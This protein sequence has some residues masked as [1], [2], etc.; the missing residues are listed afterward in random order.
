MHFFEFSYND[1]KLVNGSA[2]IDNEKFDN[3]FNSKQQA[4]HV[5]TTVNSKTGQI[6]GKTD[7]RNQ[8]SITK[9]VENTYKPSNTPTSGSKNTQPSQPYATNLGSMGTTNPSTP[10]GTKNEQAALNDKIMSAIKGTELYDWFV[11]QTQNGEATGFFDLAGFEKDKNGVYHAKQ[12]AILQLCAGYNDLYDKAFDLACSMDFKKF[13]FSDGKEDFVIWLWK[14]DYLNLGGGA[15]VG[16]YNGGGP[17]WQYGTEYAMP[18]TLHLL[19]NK[20]GDTI[21][22]WMPKNDNWWCTGFNP[23]YQDV[24]ATEISAYGSIDFSK[25][26][27]HLEMFDAFS[28][29]YENNPMWTFDDANN[30]AYFKWLGDEK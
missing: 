1:F 25:D 17:Q 6:E 14:G 8:S 9:Q 2:I 5:N 26:S 18:M 10:Q 27:Q 23:K 29:K 21:F 30:I 24:K 11:K 15:E 7:Y 13:T 20:T 28:K 4:V 19:D 12:D 16:I 22:D 3:K